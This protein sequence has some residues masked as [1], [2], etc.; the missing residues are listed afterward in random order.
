MKWGGLKIPLNLTDA[1]APDPSES[2]ILGF[3]DDRSETSV[4]DVFDE[5]KGLFCEANERHV[6]LSLL[7]DFLR[8]FYA[9]IKHPNQHPTPK[10]LIRHALGGH[11]VSFR[12]HGVPCLSW[13]VHFTLRWSW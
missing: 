7:T 4:R 2:W 3:S 13:A 10:S 6:D 12:R 8:G 11:D 1:N 9:V 5:L